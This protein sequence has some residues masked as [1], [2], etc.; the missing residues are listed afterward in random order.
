MIQYV[1][2]SIMYVYAYMCRCVCVCVCVCRMI[3]ILICLIYLRLAGR[4][5]QLSHRWFC[6]QMLTLMQHQMIL[7]EECFTT[8]AH[9]R[10]QCTAA[11]RMAAIMLQN[12]MFGSKSFAATGTEVC[13]WFGLW[14]WHDH[15]LMLH[16]LWLHNDLMWLL[17]VLIVANLLLNH[18]SSC[19]L[20]EQQQQ[21]NK[22]LFTIIIN[23]LC[24]QCNCIIW[25]WL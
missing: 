22:K 5:L 4:L 8:F 24:V 3:A 20:Y 10:T 16:L 2:M 23:I 11:I 6:F 1:H 15:I 21:Q 14:I 25:A 19:K 18:L 7:L 12:A 17:M 9:M 13:F